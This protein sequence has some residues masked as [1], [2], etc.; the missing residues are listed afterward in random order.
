V[1]G[2]QIGNLTPS[3]SF[4]HNLCFRCPNGSCE[5]ISDIYAPRV[6]QQCKECLH[7]MSFNPCNRPLKIQESIWDF[8]SQNESSLGSVRVHSRTLFCTPRSMRCDSL[9]FLFARILASPCL[10]REPKTRVATGGMTIRCHD[11]M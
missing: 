11:H 5:P 10:G 9:D 7:L 1:V 2:S 6:F 4:G 8:N 3:P